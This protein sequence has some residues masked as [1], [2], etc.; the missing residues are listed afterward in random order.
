MRIQVWVHVANSLNSM[1]ETGTIR[2][3]K[4]FLMSKNLTPVSIELAVVCLFQVAPVQVSSR[5]NGNNTVE[6]TQSTSVK[7]TGSNA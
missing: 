4:K 1:K 5:T 3:R 6:T 7:P 2:M